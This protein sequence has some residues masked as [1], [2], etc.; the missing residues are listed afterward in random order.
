[1]ATV[2][3]D[4]NTAA[5]VAYYGTFGIW[6]IRERYLTFRDIRSRAWKANKDRWSLLCVVAGVVAGLLAGLGLASAGVGTLPHPLV[7]LVVGLVIAWAGLVLRT[8]AVVALG[9]SF[10]TVVQVRSDQRVV[11][12]GPYRLVRHPSYLGVLIVFL[13]LGLGLADPLSAVVMVVL[14]A[15]G[16]ARRIVVEEAALRAGLGASYDDYARGRARL[17]PRIW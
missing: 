8:W 12:N 1:M 4:T 17:V 5:E 2:W 7:W 13:G 10:T 9:R 14:A 11:T 3:L 6:V 15:L 16:L